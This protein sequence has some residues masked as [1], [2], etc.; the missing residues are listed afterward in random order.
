[1]NADV[2]LYNIVL[3]GPRAAVSKLCLHNTE[4]LMASIFYGLAVIRVEL[5]AAA[6]FI[7]SRWP[8]E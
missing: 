5:W 2:I 8:T 3:T 7:V 1:M 6:V 4:Y